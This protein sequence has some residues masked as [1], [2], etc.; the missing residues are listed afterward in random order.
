MRFP[1]PASS[2]RLRPMPSPTPCCGGGR[3]AAEAARVRLGPPARLRIGAKQ[4]PPYGVEPQF[5]QRAFPGRL[6]EQAFDIRIDLVRV[7]PHA[8]LIA[9]QLGPV[10]CIGR[11]S[12]NRHLDMAPA[13]Q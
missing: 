10:E 11:A 8:A 2:A 4:P 3:R 9:L 1:V 5:L 12:S 7:A 6:V 13:P